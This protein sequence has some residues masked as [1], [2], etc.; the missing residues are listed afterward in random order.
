VIAFFDDR[1]PGA[2]ATIAAPIPVFNRN[3][4]NIL[5]ARA[6]VTDEV[7]N[8]ASGVETSLLELAQ[9]LIDAMGSDVPVEFGPVRAVNKVPRRLADTALARERLGFE[10]EV[11][12]EDGLRRL[13]QWWQAEQDMVPAAV[14]AVAS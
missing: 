10:A 11:T 3:Q 1:R 5:A 2:A 8:V 7:F 14:A 6:D 13:V 4:G 12:L 9:A